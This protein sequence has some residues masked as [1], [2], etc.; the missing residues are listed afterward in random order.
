MSLDFLKS[1]QNKKQPVTES[2][3]YEDMLFAQL[4]RRADKMAESND[5]QDHIAMDIPLLLRV[6]ELVREGAKT[7]VDVHNIVERLLSIKGKG[8]LT[9]NDYEHIAGNITKGMVPDKDEHEKP[10]VIKGEE[11]DLNSIRALAGIK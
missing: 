10:P 7:D 5:T 8:I 1:L 6:F 2:R 11:L 9:M 4:E 3:S